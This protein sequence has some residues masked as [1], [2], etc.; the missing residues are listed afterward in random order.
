MPRLDEVRYPS[1]SGHESFPFRHAWLKKGFDS[2]EDPE[3]FTRPDALVEL[4]VGKN[5]VF[6]IRHWME[7][8]GL[9]EPTGDQGQ[10][11]AILLGRTDLADRLLSEDGWDPYLEDDGTLWLLHRKLVTAREKATTWWWAFNRPSTATVRRHGLTGEILAAAEANAWRTS[12]NTVKRDVDCFIRTYL[13]TTSGRAS[14]EDA[15]SCP[16]CALGL[17]QPTTDRDEFLMSYGWQPSLPDATFR[18]GLAEYLQKAVHASGAEGG[19][20]SLDRLLYDDGAPGRVFRLCEEALIAR[21]AG[22]SDATHGAWVY[23]ETVGLRQLVVHRRV[24]AMDWL[25]Q[26]YSREPVRLGEI[27]GGVA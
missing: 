4:G 17:L 10:G 26:Y 6:S 14:Q 15:I 22:L 9:A 7:V 8:F 1:F 2:L 12:K 23:D 16:L 13:A 11:R 21:L 3:F 27:K 25:E 18:W 24:P 5:M 19:T 20:V